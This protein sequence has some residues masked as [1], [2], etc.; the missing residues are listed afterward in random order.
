MGWPQ[1]LQF[2]MM[3][4]A[5]ILQEGLRSSYEHHFNA[6]DHLADAM[7]EEVG[8]KKFHHHMRLSHLEQSKKHSEMAKYH[9]SAGKEEEGRKY[10]RLAEFHKHVANHHINMAGRAKS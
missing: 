2:L 3:N 6:L 5:Q 9:V 1:R 10:K 7:K 8:T 4:F